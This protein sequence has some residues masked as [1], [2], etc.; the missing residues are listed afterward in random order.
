MTEAEVMSGL[1]SGPGLLPSG[2]WP[3]G[4]RPLVTS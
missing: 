2:L 4:L 1:A 3:P